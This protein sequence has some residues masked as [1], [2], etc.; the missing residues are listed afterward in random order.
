MVLKP[1]TFRLTDTFSLGLAVTVC[2]IAVYCPKDKDPKTNTISS[3]KVNFLIMVFIFIV[4]NFYRFSG[5]Y[6]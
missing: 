4:I 6:I 1:V 5:L 2:S 3:V